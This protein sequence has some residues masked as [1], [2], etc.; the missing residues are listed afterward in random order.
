MEPWHFISF[1]Q[2]SIK[3][4]FGNNRSCRRSGWSGADDDTIVTSIRNHLTYSPRALIL[5][6]SG[7]CRRFFL[8]PDR[9]S[10]PC[11]VAEIGLKASIF[12]TSTPYWIPIFFAIDNDAS[13]HW[14][15]LKSLQNEPI[16][17]SFAN[18]FGATCTI[19]PCSALDFLRV[20][21]SSGN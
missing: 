10:R 9:F 17:A 18:E 5:P 16:W 21:E 20:V 19:S 2:Q 14:T 4:L 1:D 7:H 8:R 13:D 11:I 12:K 3:P 6:A 15:W